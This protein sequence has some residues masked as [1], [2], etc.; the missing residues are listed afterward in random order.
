[1]A[2]TIYTLMSVS[3][4]STKY[5]SQLIHRCLSPPVSTKWL[6]QFILGCLSPLLY[7]MAITIYPRMSVPPLIP[8]GNH[9]LS[10]DVCPPSYTKWPS[11]FILVCLSPLLYQMSITIYT[12]MSVPP[13]NSW[14]GS[15]STVLT[16][17]RAW[18]TNNRQHIHY[19][20]FPTWTLHRLYSDKLLF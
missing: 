4:V 8:N 10:S 16:N 7:Q 6:S 20:C 17:N 15:R 3:P 14:P 19:I 11:R 1:M 18:K 12:R 5:L 2:V 13:V 9:N